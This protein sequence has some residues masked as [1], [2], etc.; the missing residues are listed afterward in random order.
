[1]PISPL[2]QLPDVGATDARFA[3]ATVAHVQAHNAGR[4]LSATS[5][6]NDTQVIDFLEE[7]AA[8]LDGILREKGYALPI[9]TTATSALKF[10]ELANSYGA[11]AAVER[12]AKSSEQRD[13]AETLW[14]GA[15]KMLRDGGIE[16]DAPT[17]AQLALPRSQAAASAWFTRCTEF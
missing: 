14:E 11:W 3:Y 13:R 7:T 9:A 8:V 10:L 16:L 5:V 12:S 6:P 4:V 1:M 15:Q 17:D 2:E